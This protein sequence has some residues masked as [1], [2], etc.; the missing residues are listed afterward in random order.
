MERMGEEQIELLIQLQEVDLK[1]DENTKNEEDLHSHLKK[2]EEKLEK[3]E[4][5]FLDKKKELK[6]TRK[7]KME[8]ELQIDE[9]DQKL[10]RHEEEKYKVK[11]QQEFEAVEKEIADLE[12][13]KDREEES[14]LELMENEE[15]L[16]NLL[17]SLKKQLQSDKQEEE[18]VKED[19]N[20]KL[21]DLKKNKKNLTEKREKLSSQIDKLY[22]NQY[23]QLRKV[24]NGLAV[25]MVKDRV[26]GG[27][28]VKVPPSLVGQMR[29][30]EIVYCESCSRIIYLDTR[31]GN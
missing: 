25:A 19:L 28:S 18:L 17:P 31:G 8:K 5:N 27:C 2:I 30:S 12:T 22:Y 13:K 16:S 10:Q 15:D 23:G 29:R 7:G 1:I 6:N 24:R 21:G 26:C 4:Q 20:N 11:S 3:M 14:L 9:I